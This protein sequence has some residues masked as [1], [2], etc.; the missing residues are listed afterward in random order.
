MIICFREYDDL[1]AN[2]P[3]N[4]GKIREITQLDENPALFLSRFTEILRKHTNIAP[5]ACEGQV[6]PGTY[7]SNQLAPDI[8]KKLQKQIMGPQTSMNWHL[9]LAFVVFNN[10]DKLKELHRVQGRRLRARE[11]AELITLALEGK[12]CLGK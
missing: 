7:L 5:N 3:T 11:Q 9:D 12:P 1:Q 6:L 2:L 10:R 8:R 4:Y